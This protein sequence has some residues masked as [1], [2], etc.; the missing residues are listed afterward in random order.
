[1]V[2]DVLG[3]KWLFIQFQKLRLGGEIL[4]VVLDSPKTECWAIHETLCVVCVI[5]VNE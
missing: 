5:A 2:R 1:M 4:R 3:P